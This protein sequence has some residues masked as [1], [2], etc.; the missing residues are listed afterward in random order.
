MNPSRFQ[1]LPAFDSETGDLNVIIET[2]KGSRTKIGFDENIG[3]F[4]LK[5][6]LPEGSSFPFDFG[7][8]PSTLGEDGDPVDVLV[9]MD[10]PV[11]TGCLVGARLI[12]VIEA[13]QTEDG[14]TVRNDRLLAIATKTHT[15]QDVNS[16]DDLRPRLVEEI[17]QFFENYNRFRGSKFKA[18]GRGGPECARKLVERGVEMHE[19]DAG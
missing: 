17:E 10:A 2:P 19:K 4:R 8:I 14:E 1:T 13:E 7:Y 9:L 18:V 3:L 11:F 5:M 15:H 6:A 16:M 12:G